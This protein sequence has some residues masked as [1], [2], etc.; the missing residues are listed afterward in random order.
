MC[1]CGRRRQQATTSAQLAQQQVDGE[2]AAA[3]EALRQ[4]A[5]ETVG[6][7]ER[8]LASAA[9]AARNARS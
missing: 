7:A 2:Q 1:N 8:M 9:K 5:V 3:N 6:E 4:M